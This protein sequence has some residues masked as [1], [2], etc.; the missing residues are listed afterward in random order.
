VVDAVPYAKFADFD[1]HRYAIVDVTP[2]RVRCEWW[3]IDAVRDPRP[4]PHL[5]AAWE[6]GPGEPRLVPGG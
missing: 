6:V 4:A 1:D 5:G 2:E 3:F